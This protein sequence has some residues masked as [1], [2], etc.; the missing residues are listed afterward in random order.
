ERPRE[1]ARRDRPARLDRAPLAHEAWQRPGN[2]G[3][4]KELLSPPAARD[5]QGHERQLG[6]G[7]RGRQE[8]EQRGRIAADQRRPAVALE[9]AP[10]RRALVELVVVVGAGVARDAQA[11]A[12]E[13]HPQREV[14]VLVV[15]EELL[16]ESAEALELGAGDR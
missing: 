14:D 16:R 12:G 11:A 1:G 10:L 15:E 9:V 8:R 13:P 5:R 3:P 4:R 2:V 7:E 6:G